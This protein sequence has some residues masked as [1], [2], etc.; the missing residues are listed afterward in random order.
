MSLR[1]EGTAW[2]RFTSYSIGLIV[3][4]EGKEAVVDFNEMEFIFLG[5][6]LMLFV[7][8]ADAF[9]RKRATVGTSHGGNDID[10]N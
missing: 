6:R 1:W 4:A 10:I 5:F 2:L 7:D 8:E 3:A 9:L